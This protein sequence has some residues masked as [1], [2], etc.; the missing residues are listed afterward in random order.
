M[1]VCRPA[2]AIAA[3]T[4]RGVALRVPET[5]DEY[6]GLIAAQREA[7]GEDE[8]VTSAA[9]ERLR[10][11]VREGALAVVALDTASGA[12]VGAGIGTVVR[13]G[14]TELAGLAVREAYRRRGIAAAV[15]W[16]LSRLADRAGVTTAFLTPGGEVAERV[17][18]RV[19]YRGVGDMLHISL[20]S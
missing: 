14:A 11:M 12:A 9:V 17:Y 8:P 4:P 3:P 10:G 19:G 18:A 2:D 6:A 16:E 20:P 1:M 13:Q 15:T 7:F 5:D